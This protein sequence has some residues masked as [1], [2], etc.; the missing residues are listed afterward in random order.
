MPNAS[1]RYDLPWKAAL[2]HA[3][4]DFMAFF[5]LELH[6]Q[7]NWT[8]PPR[9]RDKELAGISLGATPDAMVADKRT[10]E[11]ESLKQLFK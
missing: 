1:A 5:F 10:Q 11:A 6:P 3:F 4:Q 8:R 2:T 7:I 9:F